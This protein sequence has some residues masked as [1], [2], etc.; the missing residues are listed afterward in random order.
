MTRAAITGVGLALP[1]VDGV[2]GLRQGQT[3][4]GSLFDPRSA[5]DV[6]PRVRR[7]M[8]RLACMAARATREAGGADLDERTP[9]LFGT[10]NG[11]VNIMGVLLE[12]LHEPDRVL[13]AAR[14]H[15][16]VHNAPAGYWGI[17]ARRTAGGSTLTAGTL[18]FETAM[19]EAWCL[20]AG[21]EPEV[22]VTAGDQAV[23]D[24]PWADPDHCTLDLCGSLV[25][26]AQADR[27]LAWLDR[28]EYCRAASLAEAE[29]LLRSTA[30]EFAGARIVA[31]LSALGGDA[32]PQLPSAARNPCAGLY[33]LIDHLAGPQADAPLLLFK[34][35]LGGHT[36]TLVVT[37]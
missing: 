12:A 15:N 13:S 8:S 25:L 24:A 31:D 21:G 19:L 27:P 32:G 37:P 23:T 35:G 6:P 36:T 7:R 33:H 29:D 26:E 30:A 2:D 14:F 1:G 34:A 10:A 11:E 17:L 9:L 22:Q 4:D 3:W 18:T 20:L 5:T 28:V 16:S